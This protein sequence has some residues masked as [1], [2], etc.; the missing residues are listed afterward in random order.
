MQLTLSS[1]SRQDGDALDAGNRS[2]AAQLFVKRSLDVLLASAALIALVPILLIIAVA[3]RC[4]SRGPVLFKQQR[5]GR[6]G[7]AF[8]MLKFR[9]MRHDSDPAVHEAY[10]AALVDGNARAVGDFYKLADDPRITGLGRVLRRFS[11]DELPQF[12]NVLSGDMSL[13]G[14]RPPIPYEAKLY[15]P[16][17]WQRLSVTPGMT[18]LWQ[19]SGRGL[20]TFDQMI[21]LD[22]EYVDGWSLALDLFILLRT[23]LV[24]LSGRGA[25]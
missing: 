13:V 15:A 24:V 17:D 21:D 22:L 2:Q 23:P 20:L 9:T 7:R 25:C 16:R 5:V 4:S 12:F 1:K 6:D 18:G 14:P 11:L 3:V 19:V 8:S 10:F